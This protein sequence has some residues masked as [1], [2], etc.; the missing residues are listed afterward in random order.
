MVST[1]CGAGSDAAGSGSAARPDEA[2]CPEC[3]NCEMNLSVQLVSIFTSF[4]SLLG[5][6]AALLGGGLVDFCGRRNALALASAGMILGWALQ[7]LAPAPPAPDTPPS[8]ARL[9]PQLATPTAA[10][11]FS[12][13]GI[14]ALS[15]TI[16]ILAG[17]VWIA[18]SCPAEV[19]GSVMTCISFGW[20]FGSLGVY[21]LGAAFAWRGLALG[22][23]LIGVVTLLN[24]AAVVESPRWLASRK[25]MAAAEGALRKLRPPD[26]RLTHTLAEIR[27]SLDES[28]GSAAAGDG[29]T[30]PGQ[31]GQGC[32]ST[33]TATLL[34]AAVPLSGVFAV[35]NFAGEILSAIFPAHR[36]AASVVVPLVGAVGV[37]GVSL[38]SDRVGR[39]PMLLVSALGMA[40]CMA[41]LG[42]YYRCHTS[43]VWLFGLG[44]AAWEWI[45]FLAL[46]LFMFFNQLGLGPLATVVGNE[47]VPAEHRGQPLP[48]SHPRGAHPADGG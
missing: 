41:A 31:A 25:G 45:G 18:E 20:N 13:R 23:A 28:G 42:L 19:R 4:T 15:S 12:G 46:C 34:M 40:I 22:G 43:H 39:R 26:A 5:I 27:E 37:V 24:S 47:I 6:P 2:A 29:K 48:S 1:N 3:L 9:L 44:Q 30:A 33:V 16:Q 10:L 21:A 38:G 35:F 36:N 7:D 32:C 8:G 11:L 17:S 14:A